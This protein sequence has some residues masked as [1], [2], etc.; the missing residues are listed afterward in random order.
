MRS[1]G[2]H[3]SSDMVVKM[4]AEGARANLQTRATIAQYVRLDVQSGGFDE[5]CCS[6]FTVF[7]RRLSLVAC[8]ANRGSGLW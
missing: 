7:A 1:G 6:P 2:R 3:T 4:L 8:V 5:Q